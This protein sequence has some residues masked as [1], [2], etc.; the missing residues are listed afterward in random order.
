[1]S[2]ASLTLTEKAR[3]FIKKNP[4]AQK[5]LE[6]LHPDGETAL[7]V[8]YKNALDYLAEAEAVGV[9]QGA[10]RLW[11]YQSS[12]VKEAVN[13]LQQLSQLDILEMNDYDEKDSILYYAF[14]GEWDK[15]K[16]PT[17]YSQLN[18]NPSSRTWLH[19]MIGSKLPEQYSID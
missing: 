19:Q 9:M 12:Q 1:M 13:V 6:Q 16:G 17:I 5:L 15:K 4:I 7:I 8:H 3:I 2:K 11:L 18:V 14:P 10:R